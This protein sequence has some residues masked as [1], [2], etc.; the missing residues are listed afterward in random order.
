MYF[1][2]FLLFGN[3]HLQVVSRTSICSE[4]GMKSFLVRVSC[5]PPSLSILRTSLNFSFRLVN[6]SRTSSCQVSPPRKKNNNGGFGAACEEFGTVTRGSSPISLI[7][8]SVTKHGNWW[9][10]NQFRDKHHHVASLQSTPLNHQSSGETREKQHIR[11]LLSTFS[12]PGAGIPVAFRKIRDHF[13]TKTP[14]FFV[15]WKNRKL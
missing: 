11:L 2:P 14:R 7:F 10:S 9:S 12:G 3:Y 13:P 4:N 8:T 15:P 1:D 6:A 5:S